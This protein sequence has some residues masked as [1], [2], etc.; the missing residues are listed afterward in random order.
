MKSKKRQNKSETAFLF[1]ND[2]GSVGLVCVANHVVD[3]AK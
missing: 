3:C 2:T 1:A